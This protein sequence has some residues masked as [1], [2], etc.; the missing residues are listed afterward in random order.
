MTHPDIL[1]MEKLGYL[2]PESAPH[3]IGYCLYCDEPLFEGDTELTESTDGMFC[4]MDCCHEYYE[5]RHI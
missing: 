3:K 2:P 1:T 4:S 5:I